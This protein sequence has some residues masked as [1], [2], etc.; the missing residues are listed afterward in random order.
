MG[1]MLVLPDQ[2]ENNLAQACEMIR[3][4]AEKEWHIIVL[5]ECLELG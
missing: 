4:V 5:P 3:E 1:Q 2:P